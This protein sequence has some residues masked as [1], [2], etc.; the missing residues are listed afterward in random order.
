M[1]IVCTRKCCRVLSWAVVC[2]AGGLPTERDSV[3]TIT[4]A[5]FFPLF[6]GKFSQ[7][8]RWHLQCDIRA[9]GVCVLLRLS[10]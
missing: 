10:A 8:T 6:Q 4:L 3:V 7:N 2:S 5:G 1:D 9:C